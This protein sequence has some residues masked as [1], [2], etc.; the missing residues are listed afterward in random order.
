MGSAMDIDV[1]GPFAFGCI[2]RP[3][4]PSRAANNHVQP[5]FAESCRCASLGA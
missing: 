1:M 4:L 3:L 5:H 2:P